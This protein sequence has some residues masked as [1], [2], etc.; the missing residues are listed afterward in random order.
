VTDYDAIA[1]AQ[2]QAANLNG[3][4]RLIVPPPTEPM[5]VARELVKAMFQALTGLVLRDWRR[6]F[7][8]YDGACWPALESHLVRAETY[9]WLEQAQYEKVTEEGTTLVPWNPTRHK[10]DDV[11]DALRAVVVLD[12]EPPLWTDGADERPPANEIVAMHNGLLHIPSRTLHPHTPRFFTHHALAFDFDPGAPVPQQWLAFLE[13]LWPNDPSAIAALQEVIGYVLG[14]DTRQQ[15]MFLF[16]GPRRAGK[17]TIGRVLTGLLGAHNVAAPTMASLATNFGLQ[18]LIGRPLGLISDARLSGRADSKVVVERLLSISGE[19]ALTIDRKYRDPWTGRLPTRLVILTNELPRLSDSSGA[20]ASRFIVFVLTQSF[21]GH[22]DPGLTDRL[23]GEASGIFNWALAGLDRLNA[24][25]YFEP[26][27]SGKDAVQQLE[28]LASPISAFVRDYC[29]LGAERRVPVDDL[30]KAWKAW[31]VADNRGPGTKAVFGRDLRAAVPTLHRA[32]PGD[33]DRSYVY[34]GIG[35]NATGNTVL[36]SQDHPDHRPSSPRTGPM[37]PPP[38]AGD[39]WEPEPDPE[40][41]FDHEL[42]E[43]A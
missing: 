32:R 38:G 2:A 35:L 16:V 25:G 23:L 26:P 43:P 10:I 39:A 21:L 6:D 19:D 29:T 34:E 22:E 40:G 11:I 31:C 3:Q 42:D 24:R 8:R 41:L 36:R 5:R 9:R 18:P 15:K 7:Y 28:D 27:A 4:P 30:W 14:G 1:A 13:Q 17:G 37:Y 33:T 12:G 20:L